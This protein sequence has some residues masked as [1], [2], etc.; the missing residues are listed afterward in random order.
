MKDAAE[1]TVEIEDM[2]APTD[3]LETEKIAITDS[4]IMITDGTIAET[5]NIEMI[6]DTDI[7]QYHLLRLKKCSAAT[8]AQIRTTQL[9]GTAPSV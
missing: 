9:T 7:N 1:I 2:T 8:I 6:I 3:G 5:I 4:T